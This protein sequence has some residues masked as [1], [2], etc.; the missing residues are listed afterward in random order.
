MHAELRKHVPANVRAVQTAFED[1]RPGVSYEA[2]VP[3]AAQWNHRLQAS[4]CDLWP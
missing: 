4:W 2:D 1:V 3:S